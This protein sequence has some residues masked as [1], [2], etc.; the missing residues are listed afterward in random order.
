MI[1]QLTS[2]V[3]N[4]WKVINGELEQIDLFST[5]SVPALAPENSLPD[6]QYRSQVSGFINIGVVLFCQWSLFLI[7]VFG[8]S[9]ERN[10]SDMTYRMCR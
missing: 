7:Y 2:P 9:H 8:A 10:V 3:V 6:S 5:N 4:A 1:F